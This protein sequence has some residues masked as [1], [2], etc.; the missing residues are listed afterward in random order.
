MDNLE[1]QKIENNGDA[2]SGKSFGDLL[3]ALNDFQDSLGEL[4]DDNKVHELTFTSGVVA[5]GEGYHISIPDGFKV[6][7]D[8][9]NANGIKRDFLA[10]MP[11]EYEKEDFMIGE[12]DEDKPVELL[13]TGRDT[14]E[15]GADEY[16]RNAFQDMLDGGVNPQRVSTKEYVYGE[17]KGGYIRR[18]M[19]SMCCNYYIIVGMEGKIFKFRV[20]FNDK[21]T[22]EDMDRTV[23]SWL[24]TLRIDGNDKANEEAERLAAEKAERDR[25]EAERRAKEEAERIAAEKLEQERREAE[26]VAA[27]IA[28]QVRREAE[29]AERERLEAE[30]AEKARLD[31]EKEERRRREAEEA[32]AKAEAIRIAELAAKQE[33]ERKA[34]EAAA[35]EAAR[36]EAERIEAEKRA[37]EEAKRAE[38]ERLE[39]ERRAKE[40]AALKA[41]EQ[42]KLATAEAI[43]AINEELDQAK[44]EHKASKKKKSIDSDKR[45]EIE[46]QAAEDVAKEIAAAVKKKA[47]IENRAFVDRAVSFNLE[48]EVKNTSS[49]SYGDGAVATETMTYDAELAA[50]EKAEAAHLEAERQAEKIRREEYRQKEEL[51]R[52][53]EQRKL[54]EENRRQKEMERHAEELRRDEAK[55]RMGQL[56]RLKTEKEELISERVNVASEINQFMLDKAEIEKQY[57][58]ERTQYMSFEN[59]IN[60]TLF[61]AQGKK[62]ELEAAHAESE[63]QFEYKEQSERRR[64]LKLKDDLRTAFAYVEICSEL[65]AIFRE[66]AASGRRRKVMLYKQK[67]ANREDAQEKLETIRGQYDI[68]IIN[69]NATIKEHQEVLEKYNAEISLVNEVIEQSTAAVE[70]KKASLKELKERSAQIDEKRNAANQRIRDIESKM[71]EIEVQIREEEAKNN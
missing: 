14:T 28:E 20:I 49:V 56:E 66:K 21:Y 70:E 35:A 15:L 24:E 39:A 16:F 65:E 6:N 55:S 37:L 8:T 57:D 29:Q 44:K 5:G 19:S 9:R 53:E 34:A 71:R 23:D 22:V 4:M 52:Q 60:S 11:D 36:L 10:W 58:Q 62:K 43:N 12:A 38:A 45:A 17:V 63:S 33:E 31:A 61:N 25:L 46:R 32:A 68:A 42:E 47:A 1:N 13:Q 26:R 54:D 50:T 40:E 7:R 41:E 67:I 64:L 2:K 51:K 48:D 27:E 59:Q 18:V 30:K 69:S 3:R